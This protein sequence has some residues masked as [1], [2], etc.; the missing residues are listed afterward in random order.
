M[1]LSGEQLQEALAR[2]SPVAM[3]LAVAQAQTEEE[4]ERIANLCVEVG[5]AAV[6]KSQ[7]AHVERSLK[8]A[9]PVQFDLARQVRVLSSYLQYVELNLTGAAIQRHRLAIPPNILTRHSRNQT[10]LVMMPEWASRH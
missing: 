6:T 4:C 8:E 10:G 5:T 9:P 1:R 2:L 3:E 7:F